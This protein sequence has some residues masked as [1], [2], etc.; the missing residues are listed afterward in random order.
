[1]RVVSKEELI[2]L[3]RE[4]FSK[5][6]SR[7]IVVSAWI[8]GSVFKELLS[9][10]KEGISLEV[11]IRAGSLSD[12]E[13]S[14]LAFFRE[15]KRFGGKIYLHPK[16]HSKFLIIDGRFAVVGS[17]N[18]TFMGLYPE[19]SVETNLLIEEEEK[20]KELEEF[21]ERLKGESVDYTDSVGFVINSKSAKESEIILLEDLKE[22]TYLKIPVEG[23]FLL[24]RLA[25][26]SRTTNLEG[27]TL[28]RIL[29][30]EVQDW[31]IASL[32]AYFQESAEVLTGE[33]EILGEYEEERGLF[34]TPTLP[35]KA[36]LL[37]KKLSLE[38]E[39]L[40]KVL[41]KNHSGYDMGYPAYIGK[42]YGTEVKAY[43]DL[44]KVIPMHMAILG[45][46]G[47]G[48]T[49]FTKK[50][51]KNLKEKD[52]EVFV[53]DVYGEY[54]EELRASL[55]AKEF[56]LKSVLFPIGVEDLKELLK[57]GGATLEERSSEEKEFFGVFRKALKPDIERTALSEYSLLELFKEAEKH[58]VSRVFK[59]ELKEA[60][61][62]LKRTY[63]EEALLLQ[64][65]VIREIKEVIESPKKVKVFNFKEVDITET[66][67][68]LIGLILKE[69]FI[70]AKR[71]PKDRLVV[72][73]E[74]QNVAPERGFGEIPSGKENVAYTYAKKIAMEGRKLRLGLIAVTQRPANISKFVLSQL[75]TQVIFK[76]IT[77]NDLEAV[78]VF[79]EHSKEDIFR[80]LPFLK[81]GTAFVSGLAVPFSFIFQMEEI[82]YY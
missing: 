2:P 10:L 38:D 56:V 26:V 36:G 25:K 51:L 16:L 8:R 64:P 37:V 81:P 65:Q 79:F 35:A 61:E 68:N 69:V 15:T 22:Q 82:P 24:G 21:Y 39:G 74:A 73:E 45:T 3:L 54:G 11:V 76:L 50:L 20:V 18:I 5:A 58:L 70:R 32:F 7:V 42:L 41:L 30:A 57:E 28:K 43:L 60:V 55:P 1:M 19:G 12:L 80:L 6:Q 13:V 71:E 34:K 46:T 78:S 29:N 63:G 14:D 62:H 27:D 40:K 67:I 52:V 31:K 49:T 75:N 48:K 33:L 59:E 9:L 23:G 77:K 17:S 53:F 47:S 44:D 4:L 72:I 66:K